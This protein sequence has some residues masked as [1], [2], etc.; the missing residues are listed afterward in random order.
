MA[1]APERERRRLD[2]RLAAVDIRILRVTAHVYGML[3][4][5][6]RLRQRLLDF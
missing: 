4:A 1:T 5:H 2:E 6:S 3:R